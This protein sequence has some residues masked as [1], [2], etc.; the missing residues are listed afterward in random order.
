MLLNPYLIF[1]GQCA[2]AFNHYAQCLGGKIEMMLKQGDAP[3]AARI[4]AERHNNIMHAQLSVGQWVLMGS[5][6]PEEHY[7]KPQGFS[8][9]LSVEQPAEAER[10]FAALSAGGNVTMALQETFWAKRF[11]MFVDRF[12]IPWMING[13][14]QEK[15]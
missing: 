2:E 13:G 11:G 7:E 9:T 14:M 8:V 15:A 4:P 5:D 12:G 6:A 1:N 10:L 3:I